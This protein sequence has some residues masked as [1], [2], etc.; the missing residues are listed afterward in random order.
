MTFEKGVKDA[1][2]AQ[3]FSS[4]N[5]DDPTIKANMKKHWWNR[6]KQFINTNKK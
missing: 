1:S 4:T 6:N 2:N 3:G 5:I